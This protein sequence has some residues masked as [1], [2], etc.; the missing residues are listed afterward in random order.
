M[1]KIE[2]VAANGKKLEAN[3]NNNKNY[4]PLFRLH[5]NY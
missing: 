5:Q 3:K 2:A 1:S 4:Q